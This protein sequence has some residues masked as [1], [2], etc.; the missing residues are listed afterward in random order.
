[1]RAG[2]YEGIYVN[3]P[4]IG[5][6]RFAGTRPARGRRLS[7]AGRVGLTNGSDYPGDLQQAA[8][9]AAVLSTCAAAL[10]EKAE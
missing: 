7:A 5:L 9:A 2:E 6:G 4:A 1:M 3:C 8:E 10:D